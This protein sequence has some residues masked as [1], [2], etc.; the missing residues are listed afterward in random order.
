MAVGTTAVSSAESTR[1]TA[2]SHGDASTRWQCND[3]RL[4]KHS[5]Y[6]RDRSKFH[7][8]IRNRFGNQAIGDL[9]DLRGSKCDSNEETSSHWDEYSGKSSTSLRHVDSSVIYCVIPSH[10]RVYHK[11]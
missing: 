4:E 8:A 3:A 10:A 5:S 2:I 11:S 9:T 7:P 1:A 6:E